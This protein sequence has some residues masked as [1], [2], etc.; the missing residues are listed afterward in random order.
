MRKFNMTVAGI[1]AV[2]SAAAV[3]LL[4]STTLNNENTV[5]AAVQM[6][7]ETETETQTHTEE[8]DQPQ[9]EVVITEEPETEKVIPILKSIPL[10]AE[11]QAWI[12]KYSYEADISPY[13]V[14][15]VIEKESRFNPEI[16]ADTTREYSIGLMQINKRWHTER[17]E[18]LGVTDLT[19]PKQNIAV[20]IDY[21]LELFNWREGTTLEWA[22]MAYNGGP[23]YADKQAANNRISDYAAYIIDRS[24]ELEKEGEQYE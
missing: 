21:L 11:L 6:E 1:A 24:M 16:I 7:V 3:I 12:Y 22:L 2:A 10:D 20:G 14:Y 4:G 17:M 8:P 18:R 23:G 5:A 13:L 19:D 15:A 9:T